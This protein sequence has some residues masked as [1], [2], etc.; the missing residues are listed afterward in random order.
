MNFHE[1]IAL[2]TPY[3]EQERQDQRVLLHW[4]DTFPSTILTRENE[5]A[6]LTSSAMIFNAEM[7]KALM[8]WHNIYRSWSWSGGHADGE[9]DLLEVAVREAQEETGIQHLQP[10]CTQ[11]VALDILT[12]NGHLRRG[13]YVSSHLHLSLC[14]AFIGDDA[15]P[16]RIKPDENSDVRWIELNELS[17]MVSEPEMLPVYQKIIE[18]TRSLLQTD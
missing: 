8:V 12:V 10:V 16:L 17:K 13:L 2:Y 15:Q 11:P 3:N 5:F 9:A 14:Y 18:K 6:H 7:T 4:I 1:A